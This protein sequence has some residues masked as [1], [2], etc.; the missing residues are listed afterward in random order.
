MGSFVKSWIVFSVLALVL[1]GCGGR[2]GLPCVETTQAVT[3]RKNNEGENPQ[4][5]GNLQ[6][7]VGVDASESMTGFVNQPGSRYSQAIA[8]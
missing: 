6:V 4:P 8:V 2:S 7:Q 1:A 5:F 3:E